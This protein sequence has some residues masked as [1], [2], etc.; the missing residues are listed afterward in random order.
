[1]ASGI[2]G[3]V[4]VTSADTWTTIYT[5]PASTI[6]SCAITVVNKN[7]N[8]SAII[9]I[10]VTSGASPGNN[11]FLESGIILPQGGTFKLS[12]LVLG[13]GYKIMIRSTLG[14][15]GNVNVVATGYEEQ[16]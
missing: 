7:K 13:A 2:L 8:N 12:Q 9:D 10:G 4:S 5:V 14:S 1:M 11:E 6:S 16:A 3:A 15:D